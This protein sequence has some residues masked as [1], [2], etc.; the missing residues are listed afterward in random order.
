MSQKTKSPLKTMVEGIIEEVIL[1]SAHVNK[2]V[3]S[4]TLMALETKKL[5]ETLLILNERLDTHEDMILKLAQTRHK[6]PADSIDTMMKVKQ[7][8]SKPN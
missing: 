4:L 1:S 6:D 2:I 3:T 7:K 5:A 8:P